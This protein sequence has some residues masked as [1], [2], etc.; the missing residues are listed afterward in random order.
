VTAA[1]SGYARSLPALGFDPAPGDVGSTDAL[2]RR[3][4]EIA[5]ELGEI[6]AQ[7]ARV[8][9]AGW[10][11]QSATV[12]LARKKTL[13]QALAQAAD[14]AAKLG[15]AAA[16]WSPRLASYQAEADDLERQAAAEQANQQYLA[17]RAPAVPRL[18]TD[19]A[20][21]ATALTAIRAQAKQLH[22]EYLAAAAGIR[23][24]FDLAAWWDGTEDIRKY[25]ELAL[26][27]LDT[28]TA[29][30]WVAALERLAEVPGEWVQEFG[31]A[32][33]EASAGLADGSSPTK[34]M[35]QLIKAARLGEE[36]GAKVDAWYAFAPRGL[37]RAADSISA[38]RGL[39]SALGV[40]G[41]VGDANDILSPQDTGTMGW[42]DRGVA[43]TNAG[44]LTADMVG[45]DLVMDAIPGV[46]EV[47]IAATGLYLAGDFLYHHWTPFHDVAD[48]I[49]HAAVTTADDIGHGA[50]S[51]WHSVSS[52]IGSWI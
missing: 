37:S 35:D 15:E 50:A 46:G 51:A 36:T 14:G 29:D 21:S 40:L 10:K 34:T 38:V 24:E 47:A 52:S 12:A 33:A 9:L 6:Q 44:F 39:S 30:H 31:E 41:L 4:A 18:S 23:N 49:G 27:F 26:A 17:A 22:Q 1:R 2:A 7:V 8:G 13:A 19:L 32:V 43:A 48:D 20:D 11:G 45:A 28:A 42:A 5:G 3:C 25:P 16:R